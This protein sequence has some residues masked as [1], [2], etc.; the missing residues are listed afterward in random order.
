MIRLHSSVVVGGSLSWTVGFF[1]NSVK[2]P[3][4]VVIIFNS[5]CSTQSNPFSAF[6]FGDQLTFLPVFAADGT[7]VIARVFSAAALVLDKEEA[8]SRADRIVSVASD[9]VTSALVDGCSTRGVCYHGCPEE[10]QRHRKY[11]SW[12]RNRTKFCIIQDYLGQN[13]L[14]GPEELKRIFRIS[15]Q[16]YDQIRNYLCRVQPFFHDGVDATR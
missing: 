4:Q 3:F 2:S 7:A 8:N 5:C 10:D 1:Y 6:M 14:F 12:D 11:I 15:R 13:P 9:V 16:S